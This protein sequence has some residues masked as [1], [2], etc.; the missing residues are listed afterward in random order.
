MMFHNVLVPLFAQF[1]ATFYCD[2]SSTG[3]YQTEF[4]NQSTYTNPVASISFA[5]FANGSGTA[6]STSENPVITNY[7]GT[8]LNV[9]ANNTIL[10]VIS[11]GTATCSTTVNN[12]FIPTPPSPSFNISPISPGPYCQGQTNITFTGNSPGVHHALWDFGDGSSSTIFPVTDRVYSADGQQ[13]II[14]TVEDDYGCDY[15]FPQTIEIK[16]FGLVGLATVIPD[17][18][19]PGGISELNINPGIISNSGSN[20]ISQLWSNGST[21]NPTFVNQT[22]TYNVIVSDDYGCSY[23]PVTTVNVTEYN[24]PSPV[25]RGDLTLC[26]GENILLDGFQ[27][28][29]NPPYQYIWTSIL[30]DSAAEDWLF[31][32]IG[33]AAGTYNVQLQIVAGTC[34][35]STSVVVVVNPLP[36]IPDIQS[37]ITNPCEGQPI[38][39]TVINAG[40]NWVNWSN[41]ASGPMITVFNANIYEATVTDAN[42]CTN[43]GQIEVHE[44]PYFGFL[45]SGC[46][47]FCD[48]VAVIIPGS[49]QPL[50]YDKWEWWVD[51]QQFNIGSNSVVPDLN[52]GMLPAGVYTV[53]LYLVT[54]YPDGTDC[55]MWSDPLE[56]TVKTCPC[57]ISPNGRVYCMEV[58]KDDD[59]LLHNY[60]FEIW[61]NYNCPG[62]PNVTVTSPDGGVTLLPASNPPNYLTGIISTYSAYPQSV[63]FDLDFV[64]PL[65]PECNCNYRYCMRL[66]KCPFEPPCDFPLWI[67]DLVCIGYDGSGHPIYTFNLNAMQGN[68]LYSSFY[69]PNGWL[70][71]M[72]PTIVPGLTV[73]NGTFIDATP[74]D[75]FCI[76]LYAYDFTTH[77]M[78]VNKVCVNEPPSCNSRI[79]N[80]YITHDPVKAVN[81]TNLLPVMNLIPNPAMDMV[82]IQFAINTGGVIRIADTRGKLIFEQSIELSK[83]T[84]E[85]N[86]ASWLPGIYFTSIS[87]NSGAYI[88]KKLVIIK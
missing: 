67:T 72:P 77:Q 36:P 28:L 83:G 56:I 7:T 38:D 81:I 35:L 59:N 58:V 33:A 20:I 10:L 76:Y 54:H 40:T 14:L 4:I 65:H 5:W 23:E 64:D 31:E 51:G 12:F 29:G 88:V 48:T 63:C 79:I 62:T 87:N 74:N 52:L 55:G 25:I 22:G 18:I 9:G 85:I 84:I 13:T 19:C 50:I 70:S 17:H 78:C 49:D 11:N 86:T 2:S 53:S 42:G 47:D 26:E 30:P 44:N 46:V 45:F 37:S 16:Q 71:G 80:T 6:F 3:N 21:L 82:N 68:L 39:L 41:G 60:H 32:F 8:N 24:V 69:S 43:S 57:H 75:G 34:T 1:T 61:T 73:I 66:P 27:G 15:S